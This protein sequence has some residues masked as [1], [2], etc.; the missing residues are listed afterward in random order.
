MPR[1]KK[2]T[3]P[4]GRHAIR[5]ADPILKAVFLE[6]WRQK[7]DGKTLSK[8]VGVTKTTLS[9]WKRGH[10]SPTNMYFSILLQAVGLKLI[11]TDAVGNV[12]QNVN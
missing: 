4:R 12:V 1:Y 11:I 3:E 7:I 10:T 2:G 8:R 5:T 9:N 6:A